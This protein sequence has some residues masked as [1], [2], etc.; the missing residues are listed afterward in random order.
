MYRIRSH[1][2]N[3]FTLIEIIIAVAVI[4]IL[5]TITFVSYGALR[6]NAVDASLQSDLKNLFSLVDKYGI[7]NNVKGKAWYSGSGIDADYNFTPSTGNVIDVVV[8]GTGFCI[9]GYN[10][11]GSFSSIGSAAIKESVAG[12]CSVLV[13]SASAQA[14]SLGTLT[15]TQRAS[16]GAREWW[17]IAS[18]S[19]G[20]KLVA[21][22]GN[23][24]YIYT[25]TDY[26]TTWTQRTSAGQRYWEDVASSSDGT[27][28]IAIDSGAYLYYSNDSGSSWTENTAYGTSNWWTI[29]TS[30]NGLKAL[31]GA[32]ARPFVSS[33]AGI[34][35]AMPTFSGGSPLAISSTISDD[36]T[37]MVIGQDNGY[38]FT[39]TDS[40]VTWT[41]RSAPGSRIW[42]SVASS[43]DGSKVVASS[44]AYIF[45]SADYGATWTQQT[46]AGM[47]PWWYG[48]A[49][50]SDGT[51]ISAVQ[52]GGYIYTSVDSGVTWTQQTSAGSRGWKDIAISDDGLK[53]VAIPSNESI[54]TAVYVP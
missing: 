16:S 46:G 24:G 28:L 52:N 42:R 49:M 30:S 53:M 38:L 3:G 8:D 17:D 39:S 14:A 43:S 23:S 54:Y 47:S 34:T 20:S 26:G 35:W 18:S 37:K 33:D 12:K 7:Q 27:K 4:G 36:G 25:S 9:R 11:K 31:A 6:K 15:W 1:F 32:Y 44:N 10:T 45:T 2:Q 21:S 19:D 5:A 29:S 13:A 50:S 22:V 40:G 41:Q 48:V 51:K